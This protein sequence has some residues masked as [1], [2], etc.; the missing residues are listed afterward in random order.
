LNSAVFVMGWCSFVYV[1]IINDI[2]Y[3]STGLVPL[4]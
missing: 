3:I 2:N 1:L 4:I